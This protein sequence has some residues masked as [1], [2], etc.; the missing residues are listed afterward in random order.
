MVIEESSECKDLGGGFLG[1][2]TNSMDV[3]IDLAATLLSLLGD[4]GET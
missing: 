2:S 4:L 1:R 3:G